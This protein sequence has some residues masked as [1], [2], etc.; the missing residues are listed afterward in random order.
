MERIWISRKALISA[1][2]SAVIFFALA[3]GT[4]VAQ[5]STQ[6]AG[7]D[8]DRQRIER[9]VRD[10]LLENPELMVEV[11]QRL[12]AKQQARRDQQ[13][14]ENLKLVKDQLYADE[15][16]PFVGNPNG[17]KVIV[18]FSDYNCPYCKRTMPVVEQA[19][20]Q[21]SELKV[22]LREFPILGPV[23]Q[24]AA[25][26]ALAAN[27]QDKSKYNQ[28]HRKLFSIEGRLTPEKIDNAL[29]QLGLD[30]KRL[31]S[32]MNSPEVKSAL[33]LSLQLGQMLG[34]NGTPA[35]VGAGRLIPGAV[36]AEE[37]KVLVSQVAAAGEK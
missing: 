17:S 19:V 18:E 31:K 6:G 8:P 37:L 28:V 2:A 34:I 26:A 13:F 33:N 16:V 12:E 27:L 1:A 11:M 7:S 24:Y 15:S 25:A 5:Q 4:G 3:A 32:A 29:G 10:Y 23:S 14:Q 20:K 21:D 30:M 35:F 22:Y 9:I 36:S